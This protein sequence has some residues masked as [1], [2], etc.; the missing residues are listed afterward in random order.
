[1]DAR[2]G[3][4]AGGEVVPENSTAVEFQE[5]ADSGFAA[6]RGFLGVGF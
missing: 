2:Q 6:R 5:F 4:P 1:M 3:I